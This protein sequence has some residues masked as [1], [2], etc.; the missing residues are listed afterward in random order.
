GVGRQRVLVE[1][2]VAE[3]RARRPVDD[4]LRDQLAAGPLVEVYREAEDVGLEDVLQQREAAGEVAVQRRV[5]DRQLRLVPGRDDEPAELVRERHQQ[6]AA[7]P[8]LQVLLGQ[9]GLA[10]GERARERS[11]ER[12][13]HRL[14]LELAEV[15]PERLG[16]S[17]RVAARQLRRVARR[18]RHAVYT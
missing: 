4:R 7:D 10:A 8:R 1:L 13:Y 11:R 15:D 18:H 14:D 9:V 12:L 2:V 6:R 17:P 3:L 16:E 5:A